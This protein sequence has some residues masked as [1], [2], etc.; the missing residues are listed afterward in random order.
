MT[1]PSNR[2]TCGYSIATTASHT[3]EK[4]K[5]KSDVTFANELEDC[6]HWRKASWSAITPF[7]IQGPVL[8]YT[9]VHLLLHVAVAAKVGIES[10][11]KLH[12]V[13]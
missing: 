9:C 10:L 8:I 6:K 7:H 5:P 2:G 12:L 3:R 11:D 1:N 13:N 4:L